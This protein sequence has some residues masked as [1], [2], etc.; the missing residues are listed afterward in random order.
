MGV[1]LT[2]SQALATGPGVST[3]LLAGHSRSPNLLPPRPGRISLSQIP[4]TSTSFSH[5]ATSPWGVPQSPVAMGSQAPSLRTPDVGMSLTPTKVGAGLDS[6]SVLPASSGA[7]QNSL[8]L[9]QAVTFGSQSSLTRGAA[10]GAFGQLTRGWR[11][12]SSGAGSAGSS[13]TVAKRVSVG[14]SSSSQPDSL[15]SFSGRVSTS[16]SITGLKRLTSLRRRS[17]KQLQQAKRS[18]GTAPTVPPSADVANTGN[19]AEATGARSTPPSSP[20]SLITSSILLPEAADVVRRA[21]EDSVQ[22]R[23]E[24]DGV[25]DKVAHADKKKDKSESRKLGMVDFGH[26]DT[27]QR[28]KEDEKSTLRPIRTEHDVDKDS[29]MSKEEQKS[30]C[31][32]IKTEYEV[33]KRIKDFK[34]E[35]KPSITLK[36]GGSPV[37]PVSPAEVPASDRKPLSSLGSES[38]LPLITTSHVQTNAPKV[39]RLAGVNIRGFQGQMMATRGQ[40]VPFASGP[41]ANFVPKGQSSG[42]KDAPEKHAA[43]QNTAKACE[44]KGPSVTEARTSANTPFLHPT[45]IIIQP[46]TDS[47]RQT[48]VSSGTL[49]APTLRLMNVEDVARP[50]VICLHAG[51]PCIS[52][53]QAANSR[54]IGENASDSNTDDGKR[55]TVGSNR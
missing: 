54:K 17:K 11:K 18:T 36:A 40:A 4:S 5:L 24:S 55:S 43:S 33:S 16:S 47:S 6:G 50:G 23:P 37:S 48:T 31:K 19:I 53:K 3:G 2:H 20:H 25:N 1:T 26:Q 41:Q 8:F 35:D 51:A 42:D 30:T 45:R 44:D 10:S 27:K 15:A 13:S 21:S 12:I 29:R 28:R 22:P 39:L 38:A 32:E 9:R 7:I 14:G 49:K 34:T 46:Q 52:V